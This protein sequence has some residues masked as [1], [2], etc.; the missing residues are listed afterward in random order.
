MMYLFGP[1]L[2]H[3]SALGNPC[4]LDDPYLVFFQEILAGNMAKFSFF[5]DQY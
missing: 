2:M 1:E 4:F 3:T 5:V